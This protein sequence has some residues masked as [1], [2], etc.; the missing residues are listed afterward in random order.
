MKCNGSGNPTLYSTVENPIDDFEEHIINDGDGEL[1][2][3]YALASYIDSFEGDIVPDY[4]STTHD[5]KTKIDSR[6]I[7]DLLK[8]P[9]NVF[10]LVS[11]VA[12]A[13]VILTVII[14]IFVRRRRHR[15]AAA[16]DEA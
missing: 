11:C 2:A 14:V 4:Y 5:R 7:S 1:K 12:S 16:K 9:N 15:K 8:Q 6:D 3:W 13:L 10:A